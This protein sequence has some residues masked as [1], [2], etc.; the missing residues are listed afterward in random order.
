MDTGVEGLIKLWFSV[1]WRLARILRMSSDKVVLYDQEEKASEDSL[2]CF[3]GFKL[4]FT[5][6]GQSEQKTTCGVTQALLERLPSYSQPSHTPPPRCVS[7]S[8]Q[9]IPP[10]TTLSCYESPESNT[11]KY[12]L[13]HAFSVWKLFLLW[14]KG[15]CYLFFKIYNKYLFCHGC[16][17]WHLDKFYSE[18]H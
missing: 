6:L 11:S 17:L 14:L 9:S 8:F 16:Y 10:P 15:K 4:I 18:W 2:I 3:R 1:L 12:S 13:L 7:H 5:P